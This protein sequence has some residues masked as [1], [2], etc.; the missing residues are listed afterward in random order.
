MSWQA[1]RVPTD[2]VFPG[3]C[4]KLIPKDLSFKVSRS[5]PSMTR[6]LCLTVGL[7]AFLKTGLALHEIDF[8]IKGPQEEPMV[9]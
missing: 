5:L 6:C 4:G 3:S 1:H 2:G 7:V 8:V 9:F